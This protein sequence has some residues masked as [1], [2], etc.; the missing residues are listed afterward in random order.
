MKEIKIT[1]AT[2]AFADYRVP[3]FKELD[4]LSK[5]NLTLIYNEE[6]VK[7]HIADQL[8]STLGHRSIALSGEKR[9]IG[10][11]REN[12]AFANSGIRIPYQ[13]DLIKT[14]KKTDP[15]VLISDG[16]FQ[17]TYGPL[18]VN[19]TKRIP[20]IMC[21][22]R[23]PHTERDV[24]WYRVL[25]RKLVMKWIDYIICSGSLCG[26][27]VRSLGFPDDHLYYG[28]M[29]AEVNTLANK[30]AAIPNESVLKL[31]S[32]FNAKYIFLYTGQI[33]KRKGIKE[34]VRAWH[35]SNL[36]NNPEV[37][38]V[39]IG[40]GVQFDEINQIVQSS[41]INNIHPLGRVPYDQIA[42]YYALADI[43]II[44]TLEDNWSLVVP[45]AMATALPVACSKYNGLW[46][47]MIKSENGWVFDPLEP[48]EFIKTLNHIYDERESFSKMGL[49][50]QQI[51]QSH[52]PEKAAAVIWHA[53][54]KAI[55]QRNEN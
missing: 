36:F 43:F 12:S 28:H 9:I 1:W 2:R 4:R 47:E 34:L 29:V 24:Q 6:I 53:C 50:S 26:Q 7:A 27:Y 33:I 39:L 52:T 8:N 38:L 3:V 22:E 13:K 51:V 5:G 11:N 20:H 55:K 16:F 30:S 19:M 54:N 14:I 49:I 37:G 46:P 35:E 32:K 31:K 17:W 44:P 23:T 48:K 21:Y 40:D 41:R 42:T 25:Y 15:D 45:E 10:K 18:I